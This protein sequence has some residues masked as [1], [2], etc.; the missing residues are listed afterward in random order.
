MLF[1]KF[2]NCR[3]AFI[4]LKQCTILHQKGIVCAAESN[5][6]VDNLEDVLFVHTLNQLHIAAVPQ[7]S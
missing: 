3:E 2:L 5:R 1:V 6:I 7:D 4:H